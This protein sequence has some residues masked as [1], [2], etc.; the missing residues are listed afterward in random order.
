M[1]SPNQTS[2]PLDFTIALPSGSTG[3]IEIRAVETRTGITSNTFVGDLGRT[4]AAA[5]DGINGFVWHDANS[6]GQWQFHE[7]GVAGVT[8]QI[9]DAGGNP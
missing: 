1:I 6:D 7:A 8:V 3:S 2:T 4:D 5:T 9:V